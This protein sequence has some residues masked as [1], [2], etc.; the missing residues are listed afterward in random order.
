MS[1]KY[2][3]DVRICAYVCLLATLQLKDVGFSKGQDIQFEKRTHTGK[4]LFRQQYL[5]QKH[6]YTEF[7]A[8]SVW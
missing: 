7:N 8:K 2:A 5:I 1:Q 6:T 4:Q 3:S